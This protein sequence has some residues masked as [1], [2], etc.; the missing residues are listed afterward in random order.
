MCQLS[1]PIELKEHVILLKHHKSAYL[2]NKDLYQED[3]NLNTVYIDNFE[4]LSE[5]EV[6]ISGILTD[7]IKDSE[8]FAVIGDRE[9]PTT[10]QEFP[11]RN[12][13]SLN[14]DY[15]YNHNFKV[16]LPVKDDIRI[17][18]KTKHKMLVVDY[19][20]T[21]R[22]SRVGKYR[23]SKDYLA[24][25]EIDHIHIVRKNYLK[26]IGLEFGVLRS[27]LSEKNQGWRTGV[28]LRL[29]Y[30][31]FHPIFHF[32]R[33]WIFQDLPN[34]A[35][36]N[37]YY[38]FKYAKNRRD[39]KGISKYYVFSKSPELVADLN[40]MEYDYMASPRKDKIKKLLALESPN[41]VFKGI[42]KIGKVLPHKSL[43]HRLY[44]L[45][46][47]VIITSHPDNPLIYPF[48]GNYEFLSGLSKS[49]TV[50]LQHGVTKDNIAHWLN[51]Y[52]K[53]I[54]LITTVSDKE[55]ESFFDSNYGYPEEVVQTLGFA[56]FD[57]LEKLDDKREIVF[58]PTWRRQFDSYEKEKFVQTDF[59]RTINEVLGDEELINYIEERGYKM[60]F[61]P[62]RNLSKFLDAFDIHP[63]IKLATK[64]PYR[65]IFNHSS[66]VITDFSSVVFDFAYLKKPI[67]YYQRDKNYHFD[68]DSAY[69]KY[70]TMG[71]GPV[72]RTIDDLR[73]N[74]K[75]L[76]DNDCRMD[77]EYVR[78][79]D[80]FFKYRDKNNCQRLTDAI[81]DMNDYY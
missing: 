21:S 77:E 13:F 17:S 8:V 6:Y 23:L 41:D 62:H 57:Y 7:F 64:I 73:R 28:V 40:Q 25:D 56:R 63:S 80:D 2:K 12:N 11:Q 24:I 67:I 5:E 22:L 66:L 3:K 15:A 78:R 69:F 68:V 34:M 42:N 58:M 43:K 19:N 55:R 9:Y 30:I 79:V 37:S 65:D 54:D 48:W 31:L 1:L 76:V 81:L 16:I 33:I 52:E 18:F 29:M 32:K 10:P 47:E 60:L 71:F 75:R 35:E 20:E 14:F 45:C 74:V 26:V 46:A 44:T 72:I 70:D 27:M 59:F 36:D 4:F 53:R 50:F 39:L 51:T 38:L 61:K 49:K